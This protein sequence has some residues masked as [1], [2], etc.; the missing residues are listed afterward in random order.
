M[1]LQIF[2]YVEAFGKLVYV[3]VCRISVNVNVVISDRIGCSDSKKVPNNADSTLM[4]RNKG[5]KM[6]LGLV[7]VQSEE[8]SVC[9]DGDLPVNVNTDMYHQRS[10]QCMLDGKQV[11][12]TLRIC[13]LGT[14]SDWSV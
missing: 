5:A 6:L 8:L 14:N 11:I 4:E 10:F 3:S 13:L 12:L 7:L 9:E 2:D 1:K